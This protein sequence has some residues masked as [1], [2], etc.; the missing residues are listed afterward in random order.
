MPSKHFLKN[1]TIPEPCNADWQTMQGNNQVRFCEHC[2]LHVNNLSQM[3]RNQAERLINKSGGRLCVRYE[4]NPAGV[5]QTLPIAK[6]LHRISRR[7]SGLAAGAFSAALSITSATA[8]NSITVR[9]DQP[10]QTT[11]PVQRLDTTATVLG[12]ISD[13]NGAVIVGATIYL[14]NTDLNLSLYATT[15][16]EGEF[17]VEGLQAGYYQLRIDAPGFAA[18]TA[19][20]YLPEN[21]ESRVDRSLHVASIEENV[22]VTSTTREI[23]LGGAVA[24]TLPRNPFIRAAQADDLEKVTELISRTNVNLRDED[25]G[26]TA[27]EHAVRN[28]NREMVQLLL[29]AGADVNAKDSAGETVVMMLDDD[30]TADLIWD[31]INAGAKVNQKDNNGSTALMQ[32]AETENIEAVRTLLDAGAEVEAADAEGRTALM[33]AAASGNVNVARALILAGANI[34]AT[35]HDGETALSLAEENDHTPI[36]RLLRSKGAMEAVAVKQKEE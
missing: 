14:S 12:T 22:E 17:R 10:A 20:L 26:T 21:G 2:S 9:S 11:Q 7:A 34:N 30:A 31:L 6:T 25:S 16:S 13:Q 32:A 28:A 8:Q 3:T 18:E 24:M 35:A 29:A 5:P 23:S 36:A 4:V 19:G 27:L 15:N 1:A 33:H